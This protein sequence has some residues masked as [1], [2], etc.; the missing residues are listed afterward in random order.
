MAEGEAM[1]ER[2]GDRGI[3]GP[4][5]QEVEEAN[6]GLIRENPVVRF[7]KSWRKR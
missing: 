7:A 3:V 6:K 2:V 4:T 1:N 5:P